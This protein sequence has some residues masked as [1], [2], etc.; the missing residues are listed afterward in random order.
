[1][2]YRGL[3]GNLNKNSI[4][5]YESLNAGLP[6]YFNS[7]F[8]KTI[9]DAEIKDKIDEF[10]LILFTNTALFDKYFDFVVNKNSEIKRMFIDGVNDFFVRRIYEHPNINFYLKRELYDYVKPS[11]AMGWTFRYLYEQ[12]K[13]QEY[14]T[15]EK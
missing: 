12:L 8:S 11:I 7:K 5:L 1:M 9:F 2:L 14:S 13:L 4:F 3:I 6:T 15:K 10:D